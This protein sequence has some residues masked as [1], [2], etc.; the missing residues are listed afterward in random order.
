MFNDRRRLSMQETAPGKGGARHLE[1]QQRSEQIAALYAREAA[2]I[3]RMVTRQANVPADV[4]EDACHTAWA[5]LCSHDQVDLACPAAVVQWLV[6]TATRV[7]WR[8]SRRQDRPMAIDPH[9]LLAEEDGA[10]TT[11]RSTD[12]VD[13][14]IRRDD[15][16]TRLMV[17]SARQRRMIALHAAGF[18]YQE[19]SA[20]TD[21]TR[22]TVERQLLSARHTLAAEDQEAR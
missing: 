17:L 1:R 19:I 9:P 16:R 12:P 22:R 14:V 4:L 7:A 15:A 8:Y 21:A 2:L 18:S 13:V 20:R 10:Q 3:R 5:Q 6:V 11:R